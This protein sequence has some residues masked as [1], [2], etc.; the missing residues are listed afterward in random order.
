MGTKSTIGS[1][2]LFLFW[3]AAAVFEASSA[4]EPVRVLG[5]ANSAGVAAGEVA[6]E[7]SISNTSGIAGMDFAIKF[8]E[9]MLHI[10]RIA[11]RILFLC[12]E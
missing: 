6:M 12:V 7:F 1:A 5:V 2:A 8:P 4:T 11:E 10:E 9:E 3:E